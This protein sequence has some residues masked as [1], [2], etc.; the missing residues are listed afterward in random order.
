MEGG[1]DCPEPYYYYNGTL[2]NNSI[3]LW[4]TSSSCL[5]MILIAWVDIILSF[6][7]LKCGCALNI[8]PFSCISFKSCPSTTPHIYCGP[9]LVLDWIRYNHMSRSKASRRAYLIMSIIVRSKLPKTLSLIKSISKRAKLSISYMDL[10]NLCT[11]LSLD[12]NQVVTISKSR[13]S[14]FV[15]IFG[16]PT[17]IMTLVPILE[18]SP[19]N[20]FS[21]WITKSISTFNS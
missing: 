6:Q 5:V 2:N 1:C 10:F 20:S 4:R 12:M 3:M 17:M 14:H 18:H 9:I 21:E 7:F 13:Y 19:L 16:D 8:F 15:I 11:H